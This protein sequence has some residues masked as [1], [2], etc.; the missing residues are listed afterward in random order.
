[1]SIPSGMG[2]AGIVAV[3]I[4]DDGALNT[5]LIKESAANYDMEWS[6]STVVLQTQL[7]C[8]AYFLGE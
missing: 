2:H 8:L 3:P 4:P 5:A 6:A 1:M 7:D